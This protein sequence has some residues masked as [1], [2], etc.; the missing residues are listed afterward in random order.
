M[1]HHQADS[2][3]DRTTSNN[4]Y[5]AA[6]GYPARSDGGASPHYAPA[7]PI[8]P[9]ASLVLPEHRI[10]LDLDS[11]A[12]VDQP[13]VHPPAP[14]SVGVSPVEDISEQQAMAYAMSS[15]Y[16]AGYWMGVAQ[17]MRHNRNDAPVQVSRS[18]SVGPG[19][20]AEPR[21]SVTRREFGHKSSKDGLRR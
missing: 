9:D 15:Q 19:P 10:P 13:A 1:M 4:P 11:S 2:E 7:S 18:P 12:T 6:V 5:A 21:V 14:P 3:P 16:W 8:A 17:S 20:A